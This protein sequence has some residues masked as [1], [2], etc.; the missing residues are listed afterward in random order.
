MKPTNKIIILL[1]V[2]L[3]LVACKGTPQG[4]LQYNFKQGY[5]NLVISA[6]ENTPPEI[7]YPN[8][9]FVIAVKLENQGAYDLTNGKL[10]ILGFD[11]NYISLDETE[12]EIYSIEEEDILEGKS[13]LNPSGGF[14]YL[15]FKAKSK[16]LFFGAETYLAKYQIQAD[17]DY[18]TQLSHT[19]CLNPKPYDIFDSGCKVEPKVSLNGQGSPLAITLL[20]EIIY[21]GNN[22]QVEFRFTIQNKGKGR[23]K[24]VRINHARLTD[25]PLG[26]EFKNN[27]NPDRNIFDFKEDKQEVILSCKKPIEQQL[28]YST[29]LYLDLSFSYTLKEKKQITLKK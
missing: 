1:F 16:E 17:Y 28:S 29:T 20:E 13:A 26:C 14:T 4:T 12:Q 23:I 24:Q 5:G 3:F 9:D 2:L 7:I 11:R 18:K 19:V 10:K 22:P 21:P 15:E 8:S 6:L 25:R 27:P